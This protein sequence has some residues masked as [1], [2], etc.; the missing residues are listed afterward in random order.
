[1]GSA[2]CRS[3]GQALNI[4]HCLDELKATHQRAIDLREAISSLHRYT[5][6][7]QASVMRMRM[8]SIGPLFQR[9]YRLVRD[10]CKEMESRTRLFTSGETTD[11]D[12]NRI[13]FF[14]VRFNP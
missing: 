3:A 10:L 11:L 13:F 5:S 4:H 2:S 6:S 1:M 9:F 12:K 7:L 8:I 14:Q